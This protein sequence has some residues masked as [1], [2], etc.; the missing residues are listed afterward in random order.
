MLRTWVE[1]SPCNR[2]AQAVNQWLP[3]AFKEKMPLLEELITSLGGISARKSVPKVTLDPTEILGTV[4]CAWQ[5]RVSAAGQPIPHYMGPCGQAAYNVSHLESAG[6]TLSGIVEP[7]WIEL[8]QQN[9]CAT[10][11]DYT[12]FDNFHGGCGDSV[13]A[14][15]AGWF[16][17]SGADCVAEEV[18]L[19]ESLTCRVSL[20]DVDVIDKNR[21]PRV[22]GWFSCSS[23]K[24]FSGLG[25]KASIKGS[26]SGCHFIHQFK[27]ATGYRQKAIV[28]R[29]SSKRYC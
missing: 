5:D 12:L 13:A 28:K 11:D 22:H 21:V 23:R 29:L 17:Q 10:A 8:R 1:V 24:D 9:D 15:T 18:R 27:A 20:G 6:T 7:S 19:F 2:T 25:G 3:I 26:K 14:N 4:E 16:V